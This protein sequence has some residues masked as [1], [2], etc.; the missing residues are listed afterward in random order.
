MLGIQEAQ[1]RGIDLSHL[2]HDLA[3]GNILD[4]HTGT[5]ITQDTLG[6]LVDR[7]KSR[8]SGVGETTLLRALV[9]GSALQRGQPN[10]GIHHLQKDAGGMP[11]GAETG[12]LVGSW[13]LWHA[14]YTIA[15][16]R[17]ALEAYRKGEWVT[18]YPEGPVGSPPPLPRRPGF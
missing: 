11:G 13:C 5:P 8:D 18:P 12:G 16:H 14:V 15:D 1:A 6:T 10:S 17:K 3:T 4:G 7:F 9:T 2:T